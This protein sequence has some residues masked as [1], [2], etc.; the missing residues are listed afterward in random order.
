MLPV[1]GFCFVISMLKK[2][3]GVPCHFFLY[4][5][6]ILRR[7][8]LIL[9]AGK[10]TRMKSSLPK[11]LH[12]A[13]FHPILHYVLAAAE[14]C[15]ADKILTVVGHGAEAVEAAF[16][17]RAEF[18]LQAE[19]RGTGHAVG[20]A[21]PALAGHEG[22][23]LVLCGDTP[24]LRGDTL[25]E[26]IDFHE[27][28][29]SVCSVLTA[30]LAEPYGYGRIVR[31]TDNSLQKIVEEKDASPAEKNIAEINS[32]VY[33]FDLGFLREAVSKLKDN[34][35]QG[36]LYLTDTIAI[37][38][39][40]NLKTQAWTIRDFEEVKG[41]NDRKQLSEAAKILFRRKNEELMDAGVTVVAPESTFIDPLTQVGPDTVIEPFTTIRGNCRIGA[42]CLIGPQADIRDCQFGDNTRFWQS[43][44]V[45][46]QV[47]DNGNIGPFAYLRPKTELGNTVKVGDFVEIKNSV[48][49]D[50]TKI[51]HLTYIGDSDVGSHCNIACGTITCNYDGFQ[52]HRTT[53]GDNAFVG[54]NAS[55]VSPV[56]VGEG[57]YVAAGAV[58]TEDV[59]E[60]A[61][62]VARSRQ[63]NID[64]WARKFREIRKK[65]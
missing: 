40:E 63:K 41:I 8:V 55:L 58:I 62:A 17:H 14:N 46:A 47:G 7:F 34:N 24:L 51:P 23:V 21:L 22:T 64:K 5:S 35:S 12:E 9:A 42:N 50:G 30:K 15:G 37:A 44:A 65:Q 25:R 56:H 18:V 6:D 59:P 57:A 32:G 45:E 31:A 33:C 52:K 54:C 1:T 43:V 11:V 16:A 36:E 20:Q 53:I 10:G 39:E 61:L 49:Q 27:S 13:A 29:A 48:V 38:R 3:I 2:M 26:F 4:R 60:D 19:Q 28:E